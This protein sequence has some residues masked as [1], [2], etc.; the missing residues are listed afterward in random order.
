MIA[1]KCASAKTVVSG[2]AAPAVQVNLIGAET[3][4]QNADRNRPSKLQNGGCFQW[5][6]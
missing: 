4:S 1:G 5:D 2:F 3:V 6:R